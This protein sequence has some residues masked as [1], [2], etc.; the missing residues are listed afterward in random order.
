[1]EQLM[2]RFTNKQT[3]QSNQST[4]RKQH[5]PWFVIP[6]A[7]GCK[8]TDKALLVQ[9]Q[10][11]ET[12]WIPKSHISDD[13][14]VHKE[15]TKGKLKITEWIAKQKGLDV[16]QAPKPPPPDQSTIDIRESLLLY[17]SLAK[18]YHPDINREPYAGEVMKDLNELWRSVLRGLDKK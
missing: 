4:V 14:E 17:R 7:E 9:F 16:S 18:K 1:M 8:E 2:L 12:A 11:G 5:G 15:G 3:T 13:S 6:D 10:S